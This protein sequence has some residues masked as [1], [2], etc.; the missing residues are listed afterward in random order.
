MTK[1]KDKMVKIEGPM[2]DKVPTE[3]QLRKQF[4]AKKKAKK[5]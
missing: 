3:A 1:K 4:E 5:K 2:R